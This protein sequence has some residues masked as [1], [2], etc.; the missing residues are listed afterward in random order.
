MPSL[1]TVNRQTKLGEEVG[2]QRLIGIT[3]NADGVIDGH[4]QALGN[5]RPLL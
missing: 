2:L 4:A 1:S 5:G 3:P